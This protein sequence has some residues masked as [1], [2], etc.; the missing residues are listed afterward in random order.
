MRNVLIPTDFSENSWTAICYALNF[1]KKEDCSFYFLYIST[2]INKVIK[3]SQNFSSQKDLKFNNPKSSKKRL[4]ELLTRI[5]GSFSENKN[6]KFYTL[7]DSNSFIVSIRKHIE[8]KKIELIIMG[9][10]GASDS[11]N[12]NIG[13][14]TASVIVKVPCNTL[15]IPKK[16]TFVD[17][18]EV[19]FPTDF[20]LSY[21]IETLHPL[22]DILETN[23]ANLHMLHISK[24]TVDLNANQLANKELMEDYFSSQEYWFHFL[25]NEE[26]EDAVQQFSGSKN[27]S[28]IVM[29]AKNLNYFQQTIFRT[30]TE[31]LSYHNNIPLLVL[32]E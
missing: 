11:Y 2:N 14:N 12:L 22:L 18:K 20:S 3:D 9:A 21:S 23:D 25:I 10:K 8:E 4:Q 1:F 15:I 16:A 5:S 30:K 24:K 28:I 32:H 7:T 13:S 6:H 27:N 31:K 17:L 26:I 19:V 29:M